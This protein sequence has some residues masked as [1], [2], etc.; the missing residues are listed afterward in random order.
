M[1]L[2][3]YSV[4]QNADT[5]CKGKSLYD[6]ETES[7]NEHVIWYE[8]NYLSFDLLYLTRQSQDSTFL[9]TLGASSNSKN[10]QLHQLHK[11]SGHL[12]L[13]IMIPKLGRPRFPVVPQL[14]PEPTGKGQDLL[15]KGQEW[16]SETHS[17][18]V[19]SLKA[20]HCYL[21]ALWIA[22]LDLFWRAFLFFRNPCIKSSASLGKP[23]FSLAEKL[24]PL[25]PPIIFSFKLEQEKKTC[26]N[27]PVESTPVIVADYS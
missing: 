12:H 21:L 17:L 25:H 5:G 13:F 3:Y 11:K 19:F 4:P 20:E 15:V 23:E 26:K 8:Y 27:Y 1:A 9:P 18:S 22:L 10:L 7:I 24:E 6:E 14:Y 16:N 2:T